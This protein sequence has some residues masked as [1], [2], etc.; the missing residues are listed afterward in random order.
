MSGIERRR[1][2]RY[3]L[4]A[5]VR[6]KRGKVDYIMELHN[7]SMTGALV[8][9]G[10]LAKPSWVD[11]DRTVEIGI[12]HPV[13]LDTVEVRGRVV[14][15]DRYGDHTRYAVDFELDDDATRE[16]SD[17]LVKVAMQSEAPPAADRRRPPPLP[18]T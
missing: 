2:P 18:T 8:D 14:R 10:S 7:I 15:V 16:G 6:V 17:R 1:Q 13:D 5:Q 11:M 9:M 4:M 12:I 3:E